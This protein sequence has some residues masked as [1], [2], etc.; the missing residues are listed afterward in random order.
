M[1]WAEARNRDAVRPAGAAV[2]R[3]PRSAVL[4]AAVLVAT[5]AAGCGETGFRPLYGT[6]SIGGADASEK[7]AQ[8][9]IAPIPG[10]V[11]QQIRNEVIFQTTGGGYAA[12]PAYRLEIVIRESINSTLVKRSGDASGSV[13]N[14]D[15]DFRLVRISDKQVVMQGKSVSRA[16]FE[17]FTSVFAN[18]RAR[19]D[20]ENRAAGTI[21][22][23]VKTRI[24]AYLA[25]PV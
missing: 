19:R 12:P 24:A 4:V 17:R 25:Q 16:A 22:Q 15:A 13:Y 5:L 18:V 14:L 6:A 3:T 2:G 20:A 8:V 7:L 11:G 1:W 23:D 21:A 10:R 9:E